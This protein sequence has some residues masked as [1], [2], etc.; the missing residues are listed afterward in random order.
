MKSKKRYPKLIPVFAALILPVLCLMGCSVI[1]GKTTPT[2]VQEEDHY[3][4]S[5]LVVQQ[6]NSQEFILSW[7]GSQENQEVRYRIYQ[8]NLTD[9][10]WKNAHGEAVSPA[11]FTPGTPV[12]LVVRVPLENPTYGYVGNNSFTQY[13]LKPEELLEIRLTEG[14]NREVLTPFADLT[15]DQ[16]TDIQYQVDRMDPPGFT[17]MSQA[18]LF[19][20]VVYLNGFSATVQ[21]QPGAA[22]QPDTTPCVLKLFYADGS[23][24]TLD[25]TGG[26]NYQLAVISGNETVYYSLRYGTCQPVI[27]LV[28][29][30]GV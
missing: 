26:E 9:A 19:Q 27:E 2:A 21:S 25:F 18:A 3:L 16:L 1:Q 12:T 17:S 23:Q 29:R 24:V 14:D 11:L 7:T 28:L 10:L 5:D 15:A 20:T 22:N 6:E 30:Q 13:T 4:I 8:E